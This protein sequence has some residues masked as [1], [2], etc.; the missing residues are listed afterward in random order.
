MARLTREFS[1]DT[2]DASIGSAG[3]DAIERDFDKIFGNM[4]YPNE[5]LKTDNTNEYTPTGNYNPATK[6]YVDEKYGDIASVLDLI[7]GEVV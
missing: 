3:C 1:A 2:G 4:I 5:V 7:N 6:L